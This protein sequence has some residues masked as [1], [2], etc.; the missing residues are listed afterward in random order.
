LARLVAPQAERVAEQAG[1]VVIIVQVAQAQ[2]LA[3]VVV[4]EV[5]IPVLI[6]TIM[7]ALALPVRCYSPAP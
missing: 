4:V 1:Q 6:P 7:L 5:V 2:Y 3:V